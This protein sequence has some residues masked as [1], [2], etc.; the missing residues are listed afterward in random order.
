MLGKPVI[1][2]IR[3]EWLESVRSEIPDYADELPI[4]SATPDTVESVLR[5]LISDPSL[6]KDI[7]RRSRQFALKWHSD[8]AAAR[9]F[10]EIYSNL[11][12]VKQSGSSFNQKVA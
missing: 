4:I 1:C 11:L 9:R 5:E 8:S 7:G 3:P 2:F 6:R 10:N 12:F